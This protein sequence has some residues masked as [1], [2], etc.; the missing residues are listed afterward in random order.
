MKTRKIKMRGGDIEKKD[1]IWQRTA[2]TIKSNKIVE[3]YRDLEIVELTKLTTSDLTNSN[4]V[5]ESDEMETKF[6]DMCQS[7]DSPTPEIEE[8]K[9]NMR[10][11][12]SLRN[13]ESM[14]YLKPVKKPL[15]KESRKGG[16]KHRL[17]LWRK[18]YKK[19]RK[20]YYDRFEPPLEDELPFLSSEKATLTQKRDYLAKELSMIVSNRK[21]LEAGLPMLK[22]R[23]LKLIAKEDVEAVKNEIDELLFKL[24]AKYPKTNEIEEIS[25]FI[26]Q[27]EEQLESLRELQEYFDETERNLTEVDEDI[28][29]YTPEKAKGAALEYGEGFDLSVEMRKEAASTQGRAEKVRQDQTDDAVLDEATEQAAKERVALLFKWEIDK[30]K[31]SYNPTSTDPNRDEKMNSILEL[32][33]SSVLQSLQEKRR[34]YIADLIKKEELIRIKIEELIR[35]KTEHFS[36]TKSEEDLFDMFDKLKEEDDEAEISKIKNANTEMYEKY[37]Q[38]ERMFTEL[39]KLKGDLESSQAIRTFLESIKGGK[40]KRK[41][42]RVKR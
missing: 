12:I 11:I 25:N 14:K 9:Q 23:L 20:I 16:H 35:I 7:V 33:T 18:K 29:A 15:E 2:S 39:Q 19:I 6:K 37:E 26:T 36:L 22:G 27:K 8:T 30:A 10:N 21:E 13:D 34:E 31:Y 24:G 40:R 1:G 42:R 5:L 4:A 17:S 3:K 41:T 32:S 38:D 28:V